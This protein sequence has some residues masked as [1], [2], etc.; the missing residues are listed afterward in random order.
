[1][2]RAVVTVLILAQELGSSFALVLVWAS[3][4]GLEPEPEFALGL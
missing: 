4:Q 1:M 2:V 3:D